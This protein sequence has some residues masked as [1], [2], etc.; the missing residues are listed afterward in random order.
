MRMGDVVD[1]EAETEDD[2]ERKH[3]GLGEF[4]ALLILSPSER[5]SVGNVGIGL[6]MLTGYLQMTHF[7]PCCVW[8]SQVSS[9]QRYT[10]SRNNRAGEDNSRTMLFLLAKT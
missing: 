6:G 3:P 2:E 4:L 8:I 5:S 7:F 1:S 9:S 10:A